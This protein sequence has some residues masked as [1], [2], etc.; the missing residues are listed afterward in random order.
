[1]C[2]RRRLGVLKQRRGD[3]AD[4]MLRSAAHLKLVWVAD[5]EGGTM[6][7]ALPNPSWFDS[8]IGMVGLEGHRVVLDP[9]DRALAVG[10]LP[11]GLEGTT[12]ILWDAKKPETAAIP[13][14]AADRNAK[15]GSIE[16]TIDET[17]KA[18]GKGT[19]TLAGASAWRRTFWKDDPTQTIEAWKKELGDRLPAFTVRDVAVEEKVDDQIVFVHWNMA[20][21]DEDVLGTEVTLSPSRPVGPATQPFPL[22]PPRRTAI[23]LE[24]AN[25]SQREVRVR[26]PAGWKAEAIPDPRQFQNA[27][28]TVSSVRALASYGGSI[29]T[30]RNLAKEFL[31]RWSRMYAK[32]N[33]LGADSCLTLLSRC[34]LAGLAQ[35]ASSAMLA[36][37]GV[38]AR[39]AVDVVSSITRAI[40]MHDLDA[41]S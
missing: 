24:Y 31:L 41:R 27:A 2:P 7:L 29:L 37:N 5:R 34:D 17:G 40:F 11:P 33:V 36:E 14:S 12:A 21:K 16:L 28:G 10:H 38:S 4:A 20:Q 32:E 35:C 9:S 25:R 22:T 39:F 3:H 8:V 6:A 19:L 23:E 26:W 13:E 30:L 15:M 18:S 1:M